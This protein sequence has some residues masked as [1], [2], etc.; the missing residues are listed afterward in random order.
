MTKP[1]ALLLAQADEA[2]AEGEAPVTEDKVEKALTDATSTAKDAISGDTDAMWQLLQDY[3]M[4]VV[5]AIVILVA[6]WI[7]SKVIGNGTRRSLAKAKIDETLSRFFGK[8]AGYIVLILGVIFALSK[9]GIDV[10]SFAAILAA[11]GFAVGMALSGTLGNFA[12]GVM[13]LIFRPFKV[14]DYIVAGGTEGTVE[15][16]ELFTTTL[17]T[18]DNRHI[19]LP[20]GLIHGA[21]IEN[22]TFNKTRR[23]DVNVGVDYGA[24]MKDTRK[25]LLEGIANIS[26][27]LSD[28]RAR[29]VPR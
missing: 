26:G 13:L 5:W 29:C 14:A 8:M 19:I 27:A 16:I 1:I 24:S 21:V 22:V 15:E 28:P 6:A 11:A 10:T 12:A 20:N 3:G 2:P 23:V 4:P 7:M 18:L 9:F 25:V 17:N